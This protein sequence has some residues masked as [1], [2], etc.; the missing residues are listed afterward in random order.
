MN[1]KLINLG[2]LAIIALGGSVLATTG[3]AQ[4]LAPGGGDT[5]MARCTSAD[6]AVVEGNIC[7]SSGGE[8]SCS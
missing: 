1:K 3:N 4:S 6:G 5:V 8:C 7:S 2:A